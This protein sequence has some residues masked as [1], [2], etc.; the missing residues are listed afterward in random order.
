V[1]FDGIPAPIL[2]VDSREVRTIVPFRIAKQIGTALQVTYQGQS[3]NSIVLQEHEALPALF[4]LGYGVGQAAALNQDFTPNSTSNP[5]SKGSVVMLYGTGGGVFSAV[6]PDGQ[7]AASPIPLAAP[8]SATIAGIPAVV[9]YA[10]SAPGLVAG[11]FQVNLQIPESAPSG[12]VPVILA[13]QGVSSQPA[14]T[15]AVH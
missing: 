10:G 6:L 9:E 4:A 12:F 15:I 13:I 2:Y 5:A 1:Q 8:L 11:V 7:I 14:V 3:S